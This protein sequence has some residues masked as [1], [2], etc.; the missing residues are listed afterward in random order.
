MPEELKPVVALA[1]E[2]SEADPVARAVEEALAKHARMTTRT[3]AARRDRLIDE[4]KR[5]IVAAVE[6]AAEIDDEDALIA[7]L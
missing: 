4:A 3:S 6:R 2:W 5:A 1:E 7:L